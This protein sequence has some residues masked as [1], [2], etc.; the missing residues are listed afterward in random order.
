MCPLKPAHLVIQGLPRRAPTPAACTKQFD[1]M[2]DHW[3]I[4]AGAELVQQIF[5]PWEDSRD[6]VAVFYDLSKAFDCANHKILIGEL[7]HYGVTGLRS[8]RASKR[9]A[10]CGGRARAARVRA[11]GSR[12]FIWV[13]LQKLAQTVDQLPQYN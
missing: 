4:D 13:R 10:E 7:R 3:T 6:A 5:G 1:C 2:W 9:C 11:G 8:P 12:P